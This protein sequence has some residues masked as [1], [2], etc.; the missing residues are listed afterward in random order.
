MKFYVMSLICTS[1]NFLLLE[2]DRGIVVSKDGGR[3]KK[4]LLSLRGVMGENS[5]E[6]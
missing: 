4:K 5:L 2:L 1:S 6:D 3:Y